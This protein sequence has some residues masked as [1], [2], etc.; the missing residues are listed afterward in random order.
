MSLQTNPYQRNELESQLR[1]VERDLHQLQQ[2]MAAYAPPPQPIMEH[3]QHQNPYG[4]KSSNPYMSP[5]DSGVQSG[6][7]SGA[8]SGVQTKAH[9]EVAPGD[10]EQLD[11][12]D[13]A[14]NQQ[15]FGM[16]HA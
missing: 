11:G 9:S 2:Q 6:V 1:V 8:Q 16:L 15:P 5:G 12:D 3:H 7:A 14:P 10:L 13:G 4:P